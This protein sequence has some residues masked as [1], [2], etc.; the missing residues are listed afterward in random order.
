MDHLTT[1][2][3]CIA[4]NLAKTDNPVLDE[5]L[6]IMVHRF[7]LLVD[8]GFLAPHFLSK[9]VES[10][11]EVIKFIR[12]NRAVVADTL[13]KRLHPRQRP[14]PR[15]LEERGIVPRGYFEHGH[16]LAMRSKHRRKSTTT[17]DLDMML[18]LRPEKE[19]LIKKGVV[20]KEQMEHRDY[21]Q[22]DETK[23]DELVD[24]DN[25]YYDDSGM[26]E[27]Y[28]GHI[29]WET[30]VLS[31]LL[32]KTIDEAL[33]KSC[34]DTQQQEQVVLQEMMEMNAEM[35]TLRDSLDRY[36]LNGD[37]SENAR[38]EHDENM[39]RQKFHQIQQKLLHITERQN[40][41]HEKLRILHSV[42]QSMKSLQDHY[43]ISLLRL[44][45]SEMQ[46][47]LRLRQQKYARDRALKIM[48]AEKSHKSWAMAKL[49]HTIHVAKDWNQLRLR[50]AEVKGDSGRTWLANDVQ[51]VVELQSFLKSLRHISEHQKSIV[52]DFDESINNL[53]SELLA[54]RYE[55]SKVRTMTF[56][57]IYDLHKQVQIAE[58]LELGYRRLSVASAT[59]IERERRHHT[60]K[61][62]RQLSTL[63]K[64][65]KGRRYGRFEGHLQS[66]R[67][68]E[69][70]MSN[71]KLKAFFSV[72]VQT[73]A[74]SILDIVMTHN[75]L[76]S[77]LPPVDGGRGNELCSHLYGID[78]VLDEVERR[79]YSLHDKLSKCAKFVKKI[80]RAICLERD[81][82]QRLR[83]E[84]ERKGSASAQS[85]PFRRG[86][87][88][89]P[90]HKVRLYKV[91]KVLFI[92]ATSLCVDR[93][94]SKRIK[95]NTQP[96]IA[97]FAEDKMKDIFRTILSSKRIFKK[98][99]VSRV[100]A[101]QRILKQ[102]YGVRFEQ[103]VI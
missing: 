35:K 40:R 88:R 29:P 56:K 63:D 6:Q 10:P 37:I 38:M 39:V 100:D 13:N 43:Q 54:V 85:N 45:N 78:V 24:D 15:Q 86:R 95:A 49:D 11:H 19:D 32:F 34:I 17:M 55:M 90:A 30:S 82:A 41:I 42:E 73:A 103:L 25:D 83:E 21:Y 94:F 23:L 12:Q 93:T 76:N 99:P 36:F 46:I 77:E 98:D 101:A 31:T 67:D 28:D 58:N 102:V 48:Y 71:A 1:S 92:V 84:R 68:T 22:V 51:F 65:I 60:I 26:D 3:K 66:I 61:V 80:K 4:N 89:R 7:E 16:D 47:L 72:F 69:V 14:S 52:R 53:E 44:K 50:D 97:A 9:M 59:E 87:R 75:N 2:S 96:E 57:K 79:G 5:L 62:K 91:N 33:Q 20:S 27:E 81:R 8:R 74:Q 18:K 70:I 64:Q